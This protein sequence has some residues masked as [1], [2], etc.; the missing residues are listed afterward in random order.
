MRRRQF[1]EGCQVGLAGLLAA[2]AGVPIVYA[3]GARE[4]AADVAIVG[5]GLGGCAAALAALR[6]GRTVV[7]TELTDWIGGQLTQQAVPPDEHAWIEQFG[8]NA[9]YFALRRG[10]RD[11]YR[12]HYPLTAQARAVRYLNP[13][14]GSVSRI[15]HEPRAALAVLTELLAPYASG[16]QL[17]LLLEHAPVRA[18]TEGDHVR[19]VTVRHLRSGDERVLVAP[20]VLDA[21][22]LGDLL[23]LAGVEFVT[24]FEAKSETG[25]GR[26]PEQA[27]PD[28]QQSFTCCFAMEY[29]EGQDHTIDRPDE[30][31]FWR[32]Y[33]PNLTPAWS[34]KLLSL[35]MSNPITLKPRSLGF[36]PSGA[37]QGFWL[38][39]R[40]ADPGNFVPGTFRGGITLVNWPQNDYLLGN[41]VGVTPEEAEKHIARGKQL[42]L[43]LLYWLQTEAP[44]PNGGTGW[45]GLRLRPDIVGTTDGLAKYPYIRE[46]RRIRAEF[47]VLEKHVGLEA[48]RK[49]LGREDVTAEVFPDSVGVGSY[50]IDLHPSSGGDNYIDV[51][52]LPFQIPLG[53]LIPRR[54]ENLIAACK[55]L[56][57]THVTNGCY[58]LHPVEWGIGEAAG[59]LAAFCL[60][61]NLKPRAVRNSQARLKAFQA[62]LAQ[63]GVETHWP[64]V[65][66][67]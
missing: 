58:R 35:E 42:S 34:G 60:E 31:A 63:Q 27:Q 17:T 40:I 47:T 16:G 5:G 13:G 2:K 45:K 4:I 55:N 10:I 8:G 18:E 48:R 12:R 14:N 30:Y 66:A 39:R 32:D 46:S 3:A 62:K 33:V 43:S 41:L 29:L 57:V 52:S 51:S 28:N 65:T 49:A 1:L 11:Y 59:L 37:G 64:Q 24:G 54:V 44:R 38:Y 23:P 21:T 22:E 20:Y 6:S 25:D 67:R 19:A 36:D 15:C 56:G 53:A 61:H 50:R 26:A 7:M 9:S